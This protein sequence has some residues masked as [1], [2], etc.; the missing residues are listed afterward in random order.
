MREKK[1]IRAENLFGEMFSHY[2]ERYS[3]TLQEKL[4]V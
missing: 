1:K 4:E 2:M 3:K